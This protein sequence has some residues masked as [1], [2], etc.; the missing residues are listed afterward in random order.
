MDEI[1]I[2][3]NDG[4]HIVVEVKPCPFCGEQPD[5]GH[6]GNDYTKGQGIKIRCSGCRY[7]FVDKTLRNG[8]DWIIPKTVAHWNKRVTESTHKGQSNG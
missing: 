3:L 1:E 4:R 8:I 6:V 2:H 7:E 5:I